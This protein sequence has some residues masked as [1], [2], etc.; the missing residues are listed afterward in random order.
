LLFLQGV[1]QKRVTERGFLMVNLWWNAG[2]SW[3]VDGRFFGCEKQATDS[4]FILGDS[5]FGNWWGARKAFQ[6]DA[7]QN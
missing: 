4:G 7:P 2:E 6:R 3:Q 5:R 1:W